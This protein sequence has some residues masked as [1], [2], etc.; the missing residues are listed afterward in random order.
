MGYRDV[1]GGLDG[2][3]AHGQK[4]VEYGGRTGK[5]VWIGVET[6]KYEPTPVTFV[7]AIP[8]DAYD[9]LLN[10]G[11]PL[12]DRYQLDGYRLQSVSIGKL[13]LVGLAHPQREPQPDAAL[14]KLHDLLVLPP[15]S[16]SSSSSSSSPS[17]SKI[18]QTEDENEDEGRGRV[19]KHTH[20]GT[21]MTPEIKSSALKA[22]GRNPE[23]KGCEPVKIPGPDGDDLDGLRSIRQMLDKVTFADESKAE[24]EAALLETGN[25]FE[26]E[27]GFGGFAIHYYKTY[28]DLRD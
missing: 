10:P 2:I 8:T 11:Q 18:D 28:R 4:E 12:A 23:Y 22:I 17:S 26:S 16:S 9:R 1:A 14:M 20:A 3:I 24:L 13:M 15:S 25:A 19:A 27:L 5:P 6:F 21:W 7:A